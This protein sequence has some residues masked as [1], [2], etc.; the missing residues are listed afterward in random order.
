M[1][2]MIRSTGWEQVRR[3]PSPSDDATTQIDY[4]PHGFR[5]Y[6]GGGGVK[7]LERR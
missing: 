6:T 1:L 4:E 3:N 5:E 2:P 7:A